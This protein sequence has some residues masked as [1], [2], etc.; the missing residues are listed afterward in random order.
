M[1]LLFTRKPLRSDRGLSDVD[2]LGTSK[3]C[4]CG[5]YVCYVC[6]YVR[7]RVCGW[8]CVW[9]M[10]VQCMCG[11]FMCVYVSIVGLGFNTVKEGPSEIYG[12]DERVS[13]GF[14]RRPAE[15]RCVFRRDVRGVPSL[16]SG[17]L[18]GGPG[19]QD[20]PVGREWEGGWKGVDSTSLDSRR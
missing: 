6:M 2:H 15:V 13:T 10:C 11:V 18:R 17:R 7:A 20:E 12:E 19:R 5:K 8:M 1:G 4:V 14:S 16:G 3:R 9:S